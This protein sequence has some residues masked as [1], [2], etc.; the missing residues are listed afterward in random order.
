MAV[1]LFVYGVAE[2]LWH[3]NSHF[4]AQAGYHSQDEIDMFALNM[5]VTNWAIGAWAPYLVV[6]V[7]M[8]LAGFRFNL[9]MTF[10]SCFFPVS[11]TVTHSCDEANIA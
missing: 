4:Y 8:G 2:P 5:T 11:R 6:A 1:G 10:R 7:G 3:Q 9:P